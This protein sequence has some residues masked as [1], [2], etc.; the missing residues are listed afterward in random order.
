MIKVV[1][2]CDWSNALEPGN[3]PVEDCKN[4]TVFVFKTP[5]E[6]QNNDMPGEL[7]AKDWT[8]AED[9]VRCPEHQPEVGAENAQEESLSE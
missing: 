9:G 3:A 8:V 4:D 1:I 5:K 7:L 6:Y 2:K